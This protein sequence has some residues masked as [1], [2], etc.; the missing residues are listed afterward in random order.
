MCLACMDDF[1]LTFVYAGR[2]GAHEFN[3]IELG[4]ASPLRTR[5]ERAYILIILTHA[6]LSVYI[7]TLIPR[8]LF[9]MWDKPH[10]LSNF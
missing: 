5:V 7:Y 8:L 10:F 2:A 4:F 9:S 6:W 1:G 3:Q